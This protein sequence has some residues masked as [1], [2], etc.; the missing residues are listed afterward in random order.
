MRQRRSS[1]AVFI[2]ALIMLF[3]VVAWPCAV[4]LSG[5]SGN[6]P[7]ADA[8]NWSIL[9]LMATPY[10]VVGSV[11]GWL[12]YTHWRAAAKKEGKLKKKIPVLRL[13]WIHKES[14]R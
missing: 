10:T 2:L 3:P 7:V 1:I 12:A 8:F 5:I 13:A 11:A 4:C 14:G 6:D 9:F